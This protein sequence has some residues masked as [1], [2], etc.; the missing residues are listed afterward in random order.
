MS[1]RRSLKCLTFWILG[2]LASGVFSALSLESSVAA[3]TSFDDDD[4]EGSS[5]EAAAAAAGDVGSSA[6]TPK[7]PSGWFEPDIE[8]FLADLK[9]YH[10]LGMDSLSKKFSHIIVL[11]KSRISDF[12]KYTSNIHLHT[13]TIDQE[14]RGCCCLLLQRWIRWQERAHFC[15]MTPMQ[16]SNKYWKADQRSHG[17]PPIVERVNCLVRSWPFHPLYIYKLITMLN[18]NMK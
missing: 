8:C 17:A 9:E 6:L 16:W 1:P 11:Y 7:I 13:C 10:E 18:K 4:E 3:V 15:L 14:A 12:V 2:S 5:L